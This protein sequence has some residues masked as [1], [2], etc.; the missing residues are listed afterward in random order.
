MDRPWENIRSSSTSSALHSQR[1]SLPSLSDLAQGVPATGRN[2]DSPTMRNPNLTRD[3]G[4]WSMQSPSKHS[5]VMSSSTNGIQLPALGSSHTS[6]N[7]HLSA[8]SDRSPFSSTFPNGVGP[9][10]DAPASL[11]QL[12]RTY[13]PHT[14]SRLSDPHTQRPSNDRASADF[15]A[16]GERR[17]SVDSRMNSLALASPLPSTN[18]SQTSLVSDLQRERGIPQETPRSNGFSLATPRVAEGELVTTSLGRR[19]GQKVAPPI[20]A[21]P[22]TQWPNPNAENPTKGFPYA[23]PDPELAA[24][25]SECADGDNVAVS[26][27]SRRGSIGGSSVTSSVFTNDSR[28]PHGQRRLEEGQQAP[29]SDDFVHNGSFFIDRNSTEFPGANH[30]HHQLQNKQLEGLMDDPDSPNGQTPYS[31]TPELRVSHKL[32]ERK[33]R[34]EMK[35]L[36]EELRSR[37]PADGRVSKTSKWEILTKAIEYIKALEHAHLQNKQAVELYRREMDR[38]YVLEREI[39]SLRDELQRSRPS[40]AKQNG[41]AAPRYHSASNAGSTPRP[42]LPAIGPP[43]TPTSGAMQGV[44]YST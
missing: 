10:Q 32:A 44:Q 4:N 29:V 12:N 9:G 34:S 19:V 2:G 14:T 8:S 41:D 30:H 40:S 33:R 16:P 1:Q 23:F 7:G 31:R 42:S 39:Q 11:S 35:G 22:R 17:S 6:P 43:H 20:N 5:S 28:M 3:S 37:L 13:D 27:R 24:R 25:G 18:A 36:F 21:N 15:P 26:S 38:N